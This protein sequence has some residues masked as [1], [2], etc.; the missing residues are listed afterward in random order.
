[1]PQTVHCPT[2]REP[3]EHNELQE[4][5]PDSGYTSARPVFVL[6]HAEERPDAGHLYGV[7]GDVRCR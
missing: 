6:D 1:M 4:N 5:L 7:C 2:E 3:D